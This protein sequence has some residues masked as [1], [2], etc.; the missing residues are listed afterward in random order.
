MIAGAK[1]PQSFFWFLTR[2]G[3]K[4]GVEAH[5]TLNFGEIHI[6]LTEAPEG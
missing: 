2:L 1:H 3:V 6:S 5:R 4:D